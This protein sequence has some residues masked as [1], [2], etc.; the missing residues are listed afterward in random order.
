MA[1]QNKKI[2]KSTAFASNEEAS[3]TIATQISSKTI[4]DTSIRSSNIFAV[5]SSKLEGSI[6]IRTVPTSRRLD[7]DGLTT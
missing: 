1:L 5:T 3:Y 7:D 6:A 2:S 4:L